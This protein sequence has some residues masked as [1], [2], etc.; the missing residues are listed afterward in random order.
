MKLERTDSRSVR[1]TSTTREG[2]SILHNAYV[3]FAYFTA[4]GLDLNRKE[5][6]THMSPCQY[7]TQGNQLILYFS[8]Q[9][10]P[11]RIQRQ[12]DE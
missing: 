11:Q 8:G 9:L 4:A 3:L 6:L 10:W 12:A 1:S 2:W 7:I 5:N